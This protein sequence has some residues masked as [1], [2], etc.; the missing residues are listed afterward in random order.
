MVLRNYCQEHLLGW[1]RR[2]WLTVRAAMEVSLGGVVGV[3]GVLLS[4][5]N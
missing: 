5:L 1:S 2:A 4:Y 3:V